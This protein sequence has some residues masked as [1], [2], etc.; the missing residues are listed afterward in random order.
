MRCISTRCSSS[1]RF[2]TT[3]GECGGES[4][5]AA[6]ILA[7]LDLSEAEGM[8]VRSSSSF[9]SFMG[10]RDAF[11]ERRNSNTSLG[12]HVTATLVEASRMDPFSSERV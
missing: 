4:V 10:A 7:T 3:G 9:T 12:L 2:L 11:L 8:Q 5:E 6:D 1:T